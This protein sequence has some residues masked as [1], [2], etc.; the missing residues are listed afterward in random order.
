MHNLTH[1]QKV[2]AVKILKHL[3]QSTT[4]V[5]RQ[6][7]IAN[8]TGLTQ[9]YVCKMLGML[10]YIGFIEREDRTYIEG[11]KAPQYLEHWAVYLLDPP[12][13]LRPNKNT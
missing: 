10:T 8:A 4:P 5:T 1:K 9:S 3:R 13:R 7:A 11:P 2:A 6:K 12:N